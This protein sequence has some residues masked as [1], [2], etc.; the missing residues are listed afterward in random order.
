MVEINVIDR[1]AGFII[2]QF[3]DIVIKVG[4]RLASDMENV[5][6]PGMILGDAFVSLDAFEFT[7]KGSL[8]IKV[9]PAHDLDCPMEPGHG[10]GQKHL[11]VG[12]ATDSTEDGVTRY[13]GEV[14]QG[15]I[16]RI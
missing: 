7:F 14:W 1:L 5:D 11:S 15:W 4:T 3:H 9:L 10:A 13:I 16:D 8:E 6:E 2:G 12:A